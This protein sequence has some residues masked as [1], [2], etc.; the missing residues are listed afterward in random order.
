MKRTLILLHGISCYSS[1][2]APGLGGVHALIDTFCPHTGN[3]RLDQF[4]Q[5]GR[6]RRWRIVRSRFGPPYSLKSF[7]ICKFQ[8]IIPRFPHKTQVF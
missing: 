3:E 2:L 4:A 6:I 5:I 1:K 7:K 8:P